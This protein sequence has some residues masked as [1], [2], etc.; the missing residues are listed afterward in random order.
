MAGCRCIQCRA[1]NSRYSCGREAARRQGD[2]RDLVPSAAAREHLKQLSRKGVGYKLVADEARIA[3]SVIWKIRAGERCQ[4]RKT[5]ETAILTVSAEI[6][7]GD[8]SLIA[9][10]PA[11]K[12]L[13]ELLR[14]GY[15]KTQLAKWL[16]TK[17]PALQLVKGRPITYRKAEQVKRMYDDVMAGRL[18]RD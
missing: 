5:T 17:T 18:K 16:G 4:I 14:D 1:A 11:W 3:E 2:K 10:G 6:A 15:T 7:R 12:L 9:S 13:D 8:A